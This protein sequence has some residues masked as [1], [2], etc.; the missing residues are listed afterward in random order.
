[1]RHR[2]HALCPYF[3]MFPET[4]VRDHLK[5]VVRNTWVFDPFLGRGTTAFESLLHGIHAAGC[6]TNPVAVCVSLAKTNAPTKAK[7]I[8]RINDLEFSFARGNEDVSLPP[9]FSSCFHRETLEEVLYLKRSLNWRGNKT[10]AFIAALILGLLHGESHRSERYLSN[11]MPRTISTKPEYSMSWWRRMGCNPPRR[12]VFPILRRE[13]EFRYKSM[14]PRLR[15]LVRRGDARD[16]W[17]LF[18]DL[19]DK[20]SLVITSPPYLDTTHFEEDQWLRLWFLGGHN[21]PIK[22]PGSDDRHTQ[23]LAY[24]SFLSQ[25]W[26]GVAPL[27]TSS[28]HFVIRIGGKHLNLDIAREL[29][30]ASLTLGTGGQVRLVGQTQSTNGLSQ[31]R[32]FQPTVTTRTREF[33]FKFRVSRHM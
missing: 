16:A 31:H 15:G 7:L 4:F 25:A 28:S 17:C 21:M 33:D 27:L 24:V 3:A 1:M 9:F 5:S 30:L 20:V 10:D 32:A 13:T 12:E 26:A 22:S 19:R 23:F 18:P 29:L 14:P 11:R 6:D 2:F 8:A